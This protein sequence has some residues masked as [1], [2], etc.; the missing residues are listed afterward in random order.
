M[1]KRLEQKEKEISELQVKIGVL[2]IDL[3]NLR[4]DKTNYQQQIID[5]NKNREEIR[6][7]AEDR[8]RKIKLHLAKIDELEENNLNYVE[9]LNQADRRY[10]EIHEKL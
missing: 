5:L 1:D 2:E 9:Q 6:S 8:A 4:L 3:E 7:L 10:V